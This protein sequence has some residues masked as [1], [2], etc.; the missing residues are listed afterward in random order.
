MCDDTPIMTS[1]SSWSSLNSQISD[2]WKNVLLHYVIQAYVS[3][4]L[5]LFNFK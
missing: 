5:I 3:M 1:K 2:E 4:Q